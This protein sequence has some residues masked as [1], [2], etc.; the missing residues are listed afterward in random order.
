MLVQRKRLYVDAW[1]W[2]SKS[3]KSTSQCCNAVLVIEDE[4]DIRETLQQVIELEGYEVFTA[5]N[6][7][8]GLKA[9]AERQRPGLILLDMMMPIMNGWEFMTAQKLDEKV[10]EIPVVIIS[11][12]GER[13]KNTHAVGFVKKPV[14]LDYLL[15]VVGQYC[16]V[17]R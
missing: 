6:G 2:L 14:E 1:R 3:M 9:L 5:A 8:E 16:S 4:K 10:S 17:Q 13:A 11:A 12:A 7:K 15:Q